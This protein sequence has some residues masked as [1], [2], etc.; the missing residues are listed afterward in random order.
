MKNSFKEWLLKTELVDTLG[1]GDPEDMESMIRKSGGGAMLTGTVPSKPW[2]GPGAVNTPR[3]KMQK[4]WT[5]NN[6]R[7]LMPITPKGSF[8]VKPPAIR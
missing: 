4:S 2:D 6:R 1:P 7:R 8:I 3:P 5:Q